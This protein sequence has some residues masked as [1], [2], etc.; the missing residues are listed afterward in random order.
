MSPISDGD[1]GVQQI[2]GPARAPG[3]AAA[4][5]ADHVKHT[6]DH[7]RLLTAFTAATTLASASVAHAQRRRRRAPATVVNATPAA[8]AP[9]ATSTD[10]NIDRGFLCRRR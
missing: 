8:P 1:G 10:P 3:T 6:Q 4:N 9:S 2:S 5:R 7:D